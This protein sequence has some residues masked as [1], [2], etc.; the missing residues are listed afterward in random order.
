MNL[1]LSNKM[2]LPHYLY[3]RSLMKKYY[4][5][6]IENLSRCFIVNYLH[7]KHPQP[8]S[9]IMKSKAFI[10]MYKIFSPLNR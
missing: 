8:F 5:K 4:S 2:S 7:Y 10:V 9:L 1:Y 3:Q 6:P